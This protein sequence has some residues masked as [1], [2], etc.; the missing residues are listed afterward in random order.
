VVRCSVEIAISGS[1][2][3]NWSFWSPD[4]GSMSCPLP[5]PA[6]RH[7]WLAVFEWLP[8]GS[9]P[10]NFEVRGDIQDDAKPTH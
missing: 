4:G 1:A 7:A 3:R 6:A 10:V 9:Y 8:I 5:T 2:H